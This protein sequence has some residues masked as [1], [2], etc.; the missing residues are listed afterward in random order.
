LPSRKRQ[1]PDAADTQPH[2]MVKSRANDHSRDKVTRSELQIINIIK[3]I[4]N[5]LSPMQLFK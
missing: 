2:K 5:F 4:N 3:L 1:L